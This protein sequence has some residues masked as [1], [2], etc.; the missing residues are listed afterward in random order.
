MSK[1]NKLINIQKAI[2]NPKVCI[3]SYDAYNR[4]RNQKIVP[5]LIKQQKKTGRGQDYFITEDTLNLLVEMNKVIKSFK[6]KENKKITYKEAS[7]IAQENFIF[8]DTDLKTILNIKIIK[9]FDNFFTSKEKKSEFIKKITTEDVIG[10][11]LK[12]FNKKVSPSL[13]I[14]PNEYVVIPDFYITYILEDSLSQ[15]SP[16][17]ILPL[18]HIIKTTFK[19][20]GKEAINYPSIKS[21]HKIIE[22][23][24]D[25]MTYFEYDT[26]RSDDSKTVFKLEDTQKYYKDI[27]DFK[28]IFTKDKK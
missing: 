17:F 27:I 28:K 4:L 22:A 8:Q 14:Y 20:L 12:L 25:K 13:I 26:K 5:N 1:K 6:S 3:N 7:L 19:E 2:K 21:S 23:D 10:D 16:F 9:Q 18:F 11:A 15:E 24:Y